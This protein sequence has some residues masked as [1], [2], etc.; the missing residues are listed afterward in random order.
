MVADLAM[1]S[2]SQKLPHGF[3][4]TSERQA[5]VADLA[6]RS[7]SQQLPPGFATTSERQAMVADL[8]GL[9]SRRGRAGAL[10]GALSGPGGL[11]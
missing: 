2:A 6:V 1:R 5:L 8:A 10:W 9:L 3:A 7:A 4:G 11:D